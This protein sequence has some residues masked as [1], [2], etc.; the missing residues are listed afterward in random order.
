MKAIA[1]TAMPFNHWNWGIKEL[2][3]IS[4]Q[5]YIKEQVKLINSK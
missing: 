5:Q 2:D 3:F 1:R 4:W